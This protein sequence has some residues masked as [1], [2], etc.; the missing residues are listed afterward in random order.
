MRGLRQVGKKNKM[1]ESCWYCQKAVGWE[2][3]AEL[4]KHCVNCGVLNDRNPYPPIKN[5][6]QAKVEPQPEI[7]QPETTSDEWLSQ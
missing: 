1:S 2:N 6:P 5:K 7:K 4:E 3:S